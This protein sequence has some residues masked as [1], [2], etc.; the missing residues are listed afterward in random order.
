MRQE[1]VTALKKNDL[2]AVIAGRSKGK[3]G[4]ILKIVPLTQRAFVEKVNLVKRHTK[5]S[6]KNPQ[7]GIVEKEASIH[8]SNL[9]FYCSSCSKPV[10]LGF[11]VK[12]ADKR[13]VCRACGKEAK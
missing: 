5:Q 8:L 4:K 2:V 1:R 3:Q 7:G 12:N 11:E 6:Q 9:M 13:R 10:R